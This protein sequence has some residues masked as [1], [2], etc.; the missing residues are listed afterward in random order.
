MQAYRQAAGVGGALL[1]I[2]LAV[3]TLRSD[4][5]G[6]LRPLWLPGLVM[7]AATAAVFINGALLVGLRRPVAGLIADTL[8]RPMLALLGFGAVAAFLQ[9]DLPLRAMLWCAAAGYAAVALV[10]TAITFRTVGTLPDGGQLERD[11]RRRWWRYALP[12]VVIAL[13]TDF[14]FDIDLILLAPWMSRDELAIVGVCARICSLLAFGVG[15]VYTVTMPDIFEAGA[16][17]N[18][19]EFRSRI[20]DANLV[21]VGLAALLAAAMF[22]TGPVLGFVFGPAFSD[23][24]V[25]LGILS[26]GLVVRAAMGPASLVLSF[27]DRPYASLPAAGIGLLTLVTANAVLVPAFGVNGAAAATLCAMTVWSFSLWAIARRQVQIDV[28]V[29]PRLKAIAWPPS[30]YGAVPRDRCGRRHHSRP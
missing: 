22:A 18:E 2:G 28:S 3:A 16:R 14:F 6:A 29:L 20:G 25:P 12:W 5:L 9:P 17:R 30:G 26:L 11:G 24:A 4:A 15:T 23:A 27:H 7:A 8:F 10:Q 13:A 21:A 1:V 19:A